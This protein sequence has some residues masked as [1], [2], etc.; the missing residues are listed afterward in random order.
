MTAQHIIWFTVGYAVELIAV[1]Y[2]TRSTRRRVFGALAGGAAAAWL[3]IEIIALGETAG[4]WRWQ[5]PPASPAAFL[6]LLYVGTA[7]SCTPL[8]LV[9]WRIARRF[10]WRGLAISLGFV[11]L[12]GPP[13]DYLMV[14]YFPEW[15]GFAPGVTPVIAD[16][17]AYILLVATGHGVMRIISGPAKGDLLARQPLLASAKP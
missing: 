8:Y 9:T 12:V 14:V 16:A 1:I 10:G 6:I 15:G 17:A 2:F 4:W 5:Y 3:A 7:I 13:R 11:G